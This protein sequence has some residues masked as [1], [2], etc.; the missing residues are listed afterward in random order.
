VSAA[1]GRLIAAA[2][3]CVVMAQTAEGQIIPGR[4]PI[5]GPGT[6]QPARRDT[7][8]DSTAVK[9]P[10][11]DSIAQRL[12]NKPDYTITR[13]QGDTA[14]F[15][16]EDKQ[17]D[18]L[19]AGKRRAVVDRDS[20]V[21]VSDSAIFYSQASRHVTAGG[22]YEISPGGGQ[23]P[24]KGL[25]RA[26][27]N[28][29]ERSVSVTHAHFPV[30]NGEMWYLE[31][32]KAKVVV[33]STTAKNSTLYA[34]GGGSI[35]SCDDSIPDYHFEYRE[36]KRTGNNTIVARPAVLYIKDVPVMWLPFIFSDT[37]AGRHSGILAPQ[38]GIGD[39]VRNSPTYRRNVNNVGYYWALS[40]YMGVGTWLDWRSSAGAVAND[41]G[42]LRYNADLDYKWIDRFLGGR[43]G[44]TYT[45]NQDSAHSTNLALSW[46][47]N[48]DFSHDAHLNTS[49]NYV[50]STVIQRQ[51]TFNPIAAI[52]TIA[53]AATFSN[54]YGPASLSIGGTRKQYPGRIQVDQSVPSV[55]ITTTPITLGSWLSWTPALSYSRNDSYDIDQP[56]VGSVIFRTNSVTGKQ[57]SVQARGRNSTNSSISFDTPLQI[58]GRDFKNSFR[59]TQQR[60]NFPQQVAIYD[61]DT[62][63]VKENRVYA[64]T[65][66]TNVDWTPEFALPALARNRFNLTPSVSLQNVDPGPFWVASERTNGH[67]VHQNKRLTYGLSASP[68]IFGLFPGVGPF[69]RFRHSITPSIGYSYANASSVSDEY[70]IALGRTRAGYLGNLRQNAINFGLTQNIEA[71]IRPKVVDTTGTAKADIIRL[72]SIT[73][74]PINYDFER[75]N[76]VNGNSGLNTSGTTSS[77]ASAVHSRWAGFTSETWGYSV[78]SE[79]LPG[80]DFSSQYSLFDGSTTSDTAR[81]APVLTTISASLNIGRGQNPFAVLTRLFGKAVPEAQK[82]PTPG[83]DQ[84][85][86]RSDDTLAAIVAATPVAGAPRGGD[87]FII[88]PSQG[89]RAQF[90]FSRSS[91]RQPHGTNVV[92]FDPRQRCSQ[93]ANGNTFLFDSCIAQIGTQPTIVAPITGQTAG[94]Q[95]YR[96]PPT[97]SLNSNISFNLTQKWATQWQTTYDFERHEFASQV[98]SLQRDLHDW[99][100]IFGF[101]QSPN[102]NFAFNFTIALKA[103]PDLKFD[104]NRT[105]VRTGGTSF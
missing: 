46:A 89:W 88:P 82:S 77:S 15:N 74:T 101:T 75:A 5:R 48:Q 31:V 26:E 80:F 56:G 12:L 20:Q 68:T 9:W 32:N 7:V 91:P 103:E 25:G 35:T 105:T 3:L 28:L 23:A 24:I 98:V 10:T 39:I 4:P 14:F 78:N 71:K 97:T 43:V 70:L 76:H 6:L 27:Y 45:Q 17:L 93:V 99:R 47:H 21:V 83:T 96:V 1:A 66:Y 81:F 100:A 95:L 49:L 51:N 90:Q 60:L 79:L 87:R 55:N 69:E 65:Y 102:G 58:F 57:D 36:A 61:L 92:D 62:N 11:P 53:S 40:D 13:Y 8:P 33:D 59:I 18:L 41:P 16:A 54:K 63:V 44:A 29:A 73:M 2:G 67:F 34:N 84:V 38:F 50:T 42:W 52:A 86:P 19:A 37:R 94:S 22:H 64:A 72:I 104:Y 30:N 85:R